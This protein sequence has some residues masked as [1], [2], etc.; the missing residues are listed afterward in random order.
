MELTERHALVTGGGRGIGNA[1][2]R[3]LTQAGVR[4]TILG[5]DVAVLAEAVTR[6]DAVRYVQAVRVSR[7]APGAG[8]DDL[9][10]V[11]STEINTDEDRAA[12]AAALTEILAAGKH[13]A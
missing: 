7:L 2:S 11:A 9:I 1:I 13:H 3:N 5:R 8:L 6:G 12:Y 4:V 10:I